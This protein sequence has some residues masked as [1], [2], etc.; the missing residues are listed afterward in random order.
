M[1][2]SLHV[3]DVRKT[4]SI[5]RY[6]KESIR[7]KHILL[8]IWFLS[9]CRKNRVAPKSISLFTNINTKTSFNT[10]KKAKVIWLREE[11]KSLYS[12]LNTCNINLKFLYFRLNEVL[13]HFEFVVLDSDI[14]DEVEDFG[15]C[16]FDSLKSKL[17]NLI[18]FKNSNNFALNISGRNNNGIL[19][20]QDTTTLTDFKFH[21]RVLNLSSYNF[22]HNITEILNLGLNF[23]FHSN[24]FN[25]DLKLLAID[26]DNIIENLNYSLSNTQAPYFSNNKDVIRADIS[27]TLNNIHRSHNYIP[28]SSIHKRQYKYFKELKK[29]CES[30]S[31]TI[32]KADKGNCIV[33]LNK[34][35][36]VSKVNSF[37]ESDSSFQLINQDPTVKFHSYLRK[38]LK[39]YNSCLQS[40]DSSPLRLTTMNPTTPLLRGLPKIHKPNIPIRPVVNFSN[41]PCSKL[42]SFLNSNLKKLTNFTN[43]YSV[44]S[45]VD[46]ANK[47]KNTTVPDNGILLSLDVTNLFPSIPPFE[48][49]EL[50]KDPIHQSPP[51]R[52]G[53]TSLFTI[54]RG[55][56]PPT[57]AS[58]DANETSSS[59]ET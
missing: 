10:I 40:L 3:F 54:G 1:D 31:L 52:I 7:R 16:K 39:L 47:I 21:P 53:S 20:D 24:N 58:A 5:Q 48:C 26:S 57:D 11:I 29:I 36:Y 56:R 43:P 17:H 6:R 32:T 49:I 25:N 35:D 42:A 51:R 30:E 12:T 44:L 41:S 4:N 28:T 23:N 9:S 13:T 46:L 33:I 8:K 37:L 15:K 18:K 34:P 59:C 14:R 38:S 50:Q 55:R 27:S 2:T 19:E 22:D 45:S